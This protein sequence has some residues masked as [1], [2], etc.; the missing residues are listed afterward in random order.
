MR[1]LVALVALSAALC[2]C[3]SIAGPSSV[4]TTTTPPVQL[5]P[6]AAVQDHGLQQ[7]CRAAT[8]ERHGGE[9]QGPTTPA[10]TLPAPR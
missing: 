5:D 9:P 6:C 1:R 8:A 10:G 7:T 2:G 3:A 4:P